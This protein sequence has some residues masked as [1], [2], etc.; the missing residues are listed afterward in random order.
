MNT[1]SPAHLNITN[2][3]TIKSYT[4]TTLSVMKSPLIKPELSAG[5]S[6]SSSVYLITISSAFVL[7]YATASVS[8]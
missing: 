8:H 5:F 2:K 7:K 4:C 3:H 6:S 1:T